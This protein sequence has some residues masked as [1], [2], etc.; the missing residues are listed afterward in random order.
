[1]RNLG[2][3]K[4]FMARTAAFESGRG[5]SSFQVLQIYWNC[6]L[7]KGYLTLFQHYSETVIC[8]VIKNK[9]S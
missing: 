6:R 7:R 4:N 9:V 3:V 2:S 1:M 8:P 5:H